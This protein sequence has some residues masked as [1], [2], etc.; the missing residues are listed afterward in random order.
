[1]SES[2]VSRRARTR[3]AVALL[4]T[5]V[6]GVLAGAAIVHVTR[7]SAKTAPVSASPAVTAPP[8]RV[9]ENMKMARSGV[10]VT[11]EALGLTPAQRFQI[12]RI[13]QE[14]QPRTD[15]LLRE[16]WP[17][18]RA[19]LDSVQRQV[20]QVLTP[21]QRARLTELR[22]ASGAPSGAARDSS[23]SGGRTP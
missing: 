6:S 4:I 9:I 18:L 22:R 3:G 21:E 13:M 12:A 1:M 7:A 10:P 2:D 19:L 8:Q 17:K 15:S 23:P 5:F 14:N 20:E 11:Y 16:T